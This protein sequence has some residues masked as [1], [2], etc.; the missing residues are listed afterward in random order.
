MTQ[1]KSNFSDLNPDCFFP[2]ISE[3]QIPK[4]IMESMHF[5][6]IHMYQKSLK[7]YKIS[8]VVYEHH[9]PEYRTFILATKKTHVT[10]ESQIRSV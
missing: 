6:E 3:Q 5:R 9:D 10:K 4:A 2:L 1:W 8:W 7:G